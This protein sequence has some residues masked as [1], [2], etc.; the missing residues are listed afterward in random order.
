MLINFDDAYEMTKEKAL[1]WMLDFGLDW[2]NAD[3]LVGTWADDEIR[4]MSA[5]REEYLCKRYSNHD[6]SVI[7]LKLSPKSLKLLKE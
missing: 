4:W 6:K 3:I 1:R 2:V 5:I 7:E